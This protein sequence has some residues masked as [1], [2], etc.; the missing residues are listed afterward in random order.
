MSTELLAHSKVLSSL[1]QECLTLKQRVRQAVL[2]GEDETMP[3]TTERRSSTEFVEALVRV[4]DLKV[5][6]QG[7][8]AAKLDAFLEKTFLP[9]VPQQALDGGTLALADAIGVD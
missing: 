4:A 5:E 8:L 1:Q 2:F 7:T 3:T 6:E 9:A